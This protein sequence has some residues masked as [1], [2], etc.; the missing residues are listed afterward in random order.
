MVTRVTWLQELHGYKS[1]MRYVG[2]R[3]IV[4][5]RPVDGAQCNDVTM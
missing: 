5:S 4:S 1:Y 3:S 2:A